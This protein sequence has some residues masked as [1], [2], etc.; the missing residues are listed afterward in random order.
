MPLLLTNIAHVAGLVTA[1]EY[2][3]PVPYADV[4]TSTTHKTC[5]PRSVLFGALEFGDKLNSSAFPWQSGQ[6]AMRAIA[7]KAV[8][9]PKEAMTPEFKVYQRR[10][11]PMRDH[12]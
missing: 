2:P 4:V 8:A 3:N 12:C 9:A 10:P 1:G 11:S 6:T 7:A 5:G